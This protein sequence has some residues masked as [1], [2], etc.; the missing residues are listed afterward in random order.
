MRNLVTTA[1][2]TRSV[3]EHQ[4]SFQRLSQQS[5]IVGATKNGNISKV[6]SKSA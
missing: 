4:N 2:A 3:H 1:T 6:W 5:E